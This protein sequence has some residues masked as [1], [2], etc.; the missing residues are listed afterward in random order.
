MRR[1]F[2]GVSVG[3]LCAATFVST[4]LVL[5]AG[6]APAFAVPSFARKYQTSCATCH[7]A[8]PKLNYF[9]NAFRNNGYRYPAGTDAD[10]TK[11]K[12]TSLGAEGY[13]RVQDISWD[14]VIDGLTS[15][16]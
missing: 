5:L 8:Y 7:S 6:V 1:L 13:K 3:R 14:R 11:E 2:R 9:G 15:T 12:P 10:M 4:I 16:L